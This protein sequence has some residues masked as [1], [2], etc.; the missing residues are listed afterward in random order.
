MNKTILILGVLLCFVVISCSHLNEFGV[1]RNNFS[2]EKI[3]PYE[4]DE[5]YKIIDTTKLYK[6]VSIENFMDESI[7]MKS[8]EIIKS[9]PSY[10]KFYS[11]GKVG[12]FENIDIKNIETLNPKKAES[13]LYRFKNNKFIVQKY[14]KHPQCGECFIKELV[15]R[16]AENQITLSSDNFLY[17]YEKIEIPLTFLKYSPDW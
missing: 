14:F 6:L 13:Y 5:V 16:N 8:D 3:K 4:N 11:N 1:R 10:L 15:T 12:R 7:K 9:N 17:T 2:F